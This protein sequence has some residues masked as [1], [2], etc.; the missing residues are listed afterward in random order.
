MSA[1]RPRQRLFVHRHDVEGLLFWLLAL[2][3]LMPLLV[4]GLLFYFCNSVLTEWRPVIPLVL[5]KV[6]RWA[7]R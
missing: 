1:G 2:R 3:L 6:A 5:G 4:L 7:Q